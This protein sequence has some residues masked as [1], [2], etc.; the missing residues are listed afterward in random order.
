M[1]DNQIQMPSSGGGLIRY[2]D[3]YKSK[4]VFS[5]WVIVGIIIAVAVIGVY[6]YKF[7]L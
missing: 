1:A 3:E 6:L 2:S 7:G 4:I 5:P